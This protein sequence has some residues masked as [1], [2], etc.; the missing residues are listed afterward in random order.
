M[1]ATLYIKNKEYR[2]FVNG[3]SSVKQLTRGTLEYRC[4]HWVIGEHLRGV[5]QKIGS[6]GH[7]TKCNTKALFAVTIFST[8]QKCLFLDLFL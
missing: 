2:F 1:R 6:V 3:N 4:N 5:S 7:V 8:K